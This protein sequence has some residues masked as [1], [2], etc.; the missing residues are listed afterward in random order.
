[1]IWS[2][3]LEACESW[4]PGTR[5][6]PVLKIVLDYGVN[7]DGQTVLVVGKCWY[8]ADCCNET[9]TAPIGIEC[10]AGEAV[11]RLYESGCSSDED[12]EDDRENQGPPGS[13]P[14]TGGAPFNGN[15][16][17]GTNPISLL[18][19]NKF[20]AVTDFESAGPGRLAFRRYYNGRSVEEGVLGVGWRTNFERKIVDSGALLYLHRTD[21]K[22]VVATSLAAEKYHGLDIRDTGSGWE[23]RDPSGTKEVYDSSGVL[24]AIVDPGDY[25]QTLSYDANGRLET[26]IDSFGREIRFTYTA[27]GRLE[28]VTDP[29]GNIY[30]YRYESRFVALTLPLD[31]N[32]DRLVR[33][34]LP[35]ATPWDP[36]D[37]PFVQY[38]YE[39]P[40]YPYAL[41]GIIDETGARVATWVYDD[42]L[43]AISS[44]HA[45]GVGGADGDDHFDVDYN[46]IDNT[47]TVT[48]PLGKDTIYRFAPEQGGLKV[49]AIEGQPSANC[50]LSN[51]VLEYNA[52]G[53]LERLTDNEGN[54]TEFGYDPGDGR[55]LVTTKTEAKGTPEQRITTTE[56]DADFPFPTK[57]IE[58][59]RTTDLVYNAAGR[60]ISRTVTDTTTH[61]VPYVTTGKQRIW[62]YGYWPDGLLKSVDGPLPGTG[63]TTNYEYD[64][65]GNLTKVTSPL[66]HVTEMLEHN[67]RGQPTVI[68]DMNGVVSELAYDPRGRL[69]ATTVKAQNGD[70][71]TGFEY[72][73][74]GRVKTITSAVGGA[75]HY[76][77]DDSG[78]LIEISNDLGE[79]IE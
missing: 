10:S 1:M 48:N 18:T 29:N 43:R 34:E 27:L 58:P 47:R 75:T 56:W 19:G 44:E 6:E 45:P 67:L 59:R 15:P 40:L 53:L 2:S 41:T 61:T 72:H 71:T 74:T 31:D 17:G 4:I 13:C 37:G 70:I 50:P 11:S 25:Q 57:I 63:D 77:Y 69:V 39:D 62:T 24:T 12:E 52:A 60:V 76:L 51:S 38:L 49:V 54:V 28:S 42:Q 35:D 68:E 7:D 64:T 32:E 26:V 46:D 33:V 8:P 22:V 79:R 20:E 65:L 9:N 21:G 55:G 5:N 3:A 73:D 36:S 23:V 78:R 30:R 66:L 16:D 14:E